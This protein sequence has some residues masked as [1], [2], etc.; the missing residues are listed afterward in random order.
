L[1]SEPKAPVPAPRSGD[2]TA[3]DNAA[4]EQLVAEAEASLQTSAVALAA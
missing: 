1:G 3:L 4:L 2:A